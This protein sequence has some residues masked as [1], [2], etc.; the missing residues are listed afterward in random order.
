MAKDNLPVYN[1][2]LE[3]VETESG[4]FMDYISIVKDPAIMVQGFRFSELSEN[5]ESKEIFFS[6]VQDEQYIVAP[7]AIPNI[8]IF[9][10]DSDGFEYYVKFSEKVIGELLQDFQSNPKINKINM[11]HKTDVKS[12]FVEEIWKIE[13]QNNDKSNMYG[14]SLPVGTVMSKV[15]VKDKIEWEDI[16]AGDRSSFSL[17]AWLGLTID[18]FAAKLKAQMNKQT[19]AA[20]KT[21]SGEEIWVDGELA[22]D[23]NVYCNEPTVLLINDQRSEMK[24]PVW[25]NIVELEDGKIL[26]IA[27]GKIV[28][29]T[30]K[31]TTSTETSASGD[32]QTKQEQMSK[33]KFA[34][35]MS[36]DGKKFYVEGEIAVGAAILFIDENLDK[37]PA[38]DGDIVLE[39]E[40][41][42]TVK[43]GKIEAI[44]PKAEMADA[45]VAPTI[46]EAAIMAIIQP[47]LD[48]IVKAIADL[49]T[50]VEADT[51]ADATEMKKQEMS[52]TPKSR[53]EELFK[54]MGK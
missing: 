5:I 51:A 15:R 9:R 31:E 52:E 38:P 48:E 53:L 4:H 13:D 42:I 6:D 16:K 11:D 21:A 50:L 19:Y 20:V 27:E 47:K 2:T 41:T 37:T 8:N 44:T 32:T 54:Q 34:D 10:R 39:D 1:I 14:F 49:K 25:A 18:K 12:A 17:E 7:V 28:E 40:S 29:I 24:Y 46:D 3:D 23:T 33:Q 43:D 30:Q 22:V 36:A 45:P 35:V 26:T